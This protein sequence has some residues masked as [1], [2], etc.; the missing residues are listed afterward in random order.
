MAQVVAPD[1]GVL[2]EGLSL[3]PRPHTVGYWFGGEAL[4]DAAEGFDGCSI[5]GLSCL[6]LREHCHV[7]HTWV[8]TIAARCQHVSAADY[9]DG[10][11]Q[12]KIFLLHTC[13]V[14]DVIIVT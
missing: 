9:E 11:Q 14:F 5:N 12:P 10:G 4:V 7:G 6:P 13:F 1:V 8:I 3:H 2:L